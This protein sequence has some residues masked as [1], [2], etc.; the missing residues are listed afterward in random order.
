MT[1]PHLVWLPRGHTDS[2]LFVTLDSTEMASC[3][4]PPL[5]AVRENGCD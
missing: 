3:K 2:E 1:L 4:Q 5:T